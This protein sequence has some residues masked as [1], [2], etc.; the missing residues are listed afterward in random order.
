V[1]VPA[2]APAAQASLGIDV[3]VAPALPY[4]IGI[5]DAEN[6]EPE[7]S[8]ANNVRVVRWAASDPYET[9]GT[10]RVCPTCPFKLLSQANAAVR[11]GQTILVEPS[12]ALLSDCLVVTKNRVTIR[13]VLDAAG[14]R[15]ALGSKSCVGKG[16]IVLQDPSVTDLTIEGLEVV[17]AAVADH[18]GAAVRF[19]GRN[20]TL[21]NVYFHGNQNG[22]LT[23]QGGPLGAGT[24]RIEHSVFAG[25][26]SATRPGYQH[27]VYASGAVG[28][29]LEF[30]GNLSVGAMHEG[31]E[32]KSRAERTTVSCSVLAALGAQD[33]YTIDLPQAGDATIRDS[34]L[35]QGPAS[36]NKAMFSYGRESALHA[37]RALRFIGNRVLDDHP[38]GYFFALGR[39]SRLTLDGDVLVGAGPL[40]GNGPGP[41]SDTATRHRSRA[42]YRAS[43]GEALGDWSADTPSLPPLPPGCE[44]IHP[45]RLPSLD[46]YLNEVVRGALPTPA[47]VVP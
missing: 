6:T 7:S 3:V 14:R 29:I 33:S 43:T 46:A 2:L 27:N 16:V 4:L 15:P 8:K 32:L 19:Q 30:H 9:P 13:G 21:R 39:G 42:D 24:I 36:S 17:G 41:M 34:V 22:L 28:T 1:E 25:N 11:D 40:V 18:N 35:Q 12:R 10:L 38:S 45:R 5:A 47:V 31:H 26:G 23:S 44:R 20:L 37:K